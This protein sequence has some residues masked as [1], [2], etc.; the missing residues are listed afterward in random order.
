MEPRVIGSIPVCRK[1]LTKV[2]MSGPNTLRPSV[3]EILNWKVA[4]RF[5][6][7]LASLNKSLLIKFE[8]MF[9]TSLIIV[10]QLVSQS[11]CTSFENNLLH[12]T[13]IVFFVCDVFS[14]FSLNTQYF[15][16]YSSINCHKVENFCFLITML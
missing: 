3:F 11:I 13:I 16:L 8:I 1:V 7:L 10:S 15:I 2:M 12:S 9:G 5:L 4:V 6:V 14:T